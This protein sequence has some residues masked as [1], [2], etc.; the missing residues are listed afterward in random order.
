MKKKDTMTPSTNPT[1]LKNDVIQE[2]WAIMDPTIVEDLTAYMMDG[3][4]ESLFVVLTQ[5]VFAKLLQSVK[6]EP[7]S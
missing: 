7:K 1:L 5:E 6:R 4:W 2:L 3:I